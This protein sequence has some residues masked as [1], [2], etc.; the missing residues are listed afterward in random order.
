MK[1]HLMATGTT[2]MRQ[3]L[4]PAT[5]AAFFGA[6]AIL[7]SA[8][9]SA[10]VH[11]DADDPVQGGSATVTFR[12]PNESGSGSPTIGLSVALPD[13]TS[14]STAAM[15]G[16]TVKLDEDRQAGTVRS[17]TWSAQPG[18]GIGVD[19]FGLFVMRVKLPETATAT[20]PA[21]QTYA[22][23]T[24]V[25]W[26]Q[27]AL[28]GGGEPERPAPSLTLGASSGGH[29]EG[30]HS[31]RSGT[32]ESPAA[33]SAPPASPA[34]AS[35]EAHPPAESGTPLGSGSDNVARALGGVALLLAALGVALAAV[36][37]RA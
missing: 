3:A 7:G 24:V 36:R 20:F 30:E 25:K 4:I 1:A 14:V 32:P 22:D 17:I 2:P 16:W 21:T 13:L 6:A 34:P 11:A 29:Q 31:L 5:A 8:P 19:Q 9:A 35:A 27:T 23:G 12:V 10:H 26:D 15:P 33:P 28:P 18:N 37:L